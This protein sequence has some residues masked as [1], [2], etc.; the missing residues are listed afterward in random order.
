[1]NIPLIIIL[2][3]FSLS[4]IAGA[5]DTGSDSD[6]EGAETAIRKEKTK[7]LD[8]TD[9]VDNYAD[10]SDFQEG[11]DAEEAGAESFYHMGRMLG[12]GVDIGVAGFT[13]GYSQMNSPAMRLGIRATYFFSLSFAMEASF[14]YQKH[15]FYIPDPDSSING[16]E[17]TNKLLTSAAAVRYFLDTRSWSDFISWVN[18]NFYLG[19]EYITITTDAYYGPSAPPVQ[20]ENQQS[21]TINEGIWALAVGGGLE[22][23]LSGMTYLGLMG[24]YHYATYPEE[25]TYQREISFTGD[26]W[27]FDTSIIFYF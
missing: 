1:M 27:S 10:Y 7:V 21:Y 17:G 3:I 6:F 5:E 2:F 13:Q 9:F 14:H 22:I 18:P 20:Y 25:G 4:S 26:S 23:K 16:W 15:P 12:V 11:Q 19:L 24:K 8:S